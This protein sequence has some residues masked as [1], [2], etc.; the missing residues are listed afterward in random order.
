MISGFGFVES[1]WGE[2]GWREGEGEGEGEVRFSEGGCVG[3]GV[4]RS[5]VVEICCVEG[6]EI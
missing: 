2:S 5:E 3:G 1:S 6:L 4:G